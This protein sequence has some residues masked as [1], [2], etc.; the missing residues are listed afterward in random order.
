[1]KSDA[2][3]AAMEV[4]IAG[5]GKIAESL[6]LA[7]AKSGSG[8]AAHNLGTLYVT[9]AAGVSPDAERSAY[10]Y[11]RAVDS[12]FEATIASNPEWFKKPNET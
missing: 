3:S 6:L 5:D 4:L 2:V 7:L 8:P 9:G 11:Q 10:W 1:M 12:G